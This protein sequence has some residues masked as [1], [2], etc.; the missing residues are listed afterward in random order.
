M[1]STGLIITGPSI[2]QKGKRHIAIMH[3][4]RAVI[5]STV[6]PEEEK[7]IVDLFSRTIIYDDGTMEILPNT[8]GSKIVIRAIEGEIVSLTKGRAF[9]YDGE[10]TDTFVETFPNGESKVYSDSIPSW[11][12]P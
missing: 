9:S 8:E 10:E 5:S 3:S 12:E 7:N 2:S 6:D 4:S 11:I 1:L